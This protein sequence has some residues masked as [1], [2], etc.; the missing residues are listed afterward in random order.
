MLNL[1][2]RE[3]NRI[4]AIVNAGEALDETLAWTEEERRFYQ[5][6]CKESQEMHERHGVYPVFALCELD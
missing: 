6:L 4:I 1:S 5:N 2:A 3:M